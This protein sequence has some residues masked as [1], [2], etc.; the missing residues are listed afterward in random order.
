MLF[1]RGISTFMGWRCRSG[2]IFLIGTAIDRAAIAPLI[3]GMS[4]I[5]TYLKRTGLSQRQ[6]AELLNCSQSLVSQWITGET[7]MTAERALE[8]ERVTSG[9]IKR[10]QLL[11]ELYRGMAA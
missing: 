5:A 2:F 3:C 6:F 8:I 1:Y 10:Q 7:R 4:A 9:K 11:P